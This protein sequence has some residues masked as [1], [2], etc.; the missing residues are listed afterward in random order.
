MTPD[1]SDNNNDDDTGIKRSTTHTQRLYTQK[2]SVEV[3]VEQ[4]ELLAH[5]PIRVV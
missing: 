5:Q 3:P 4:L 2:H 1:G